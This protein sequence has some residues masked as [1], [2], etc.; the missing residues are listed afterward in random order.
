LLPRIPTYLNMSKL[1][2]SKDFIEDF[3]RA[4]NTFLYQVVFDPRKRCQRPLTP[5]PQND[6][7]QE[8]DQ[9]DLVKSSGGFSNDNYF[10]QAGEIVPSELAVRLALGNQVDQ[11][12]GTDKF[13]LPPIVPEWSIWHES[14]ENSGNRKRHLEEGKGEKEG[15]GADFQEHS[16]PYSTGRED[17]GQCSIMN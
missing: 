3:I 1:S 6:N 7:N 13:C 8:T 5:Y 4:E 12:E 16:S 2:V 15:C 9:G 17:A 11:S 14:F 10:S